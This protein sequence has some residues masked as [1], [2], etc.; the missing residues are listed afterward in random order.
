HAMQ[1]VCQFGKSL[2]FNALDEVRG[3]GC[4]VVPAHAGKNYPAISAAPYVIG[5]Q[6]LTL[7]GLAGGRAKAPE[8]G[9]SE[10]L[11]MSDVTEADVNA[12]G[13]PAAKKGLPKMALIGGGVAALLIVAGGG[14]FFLMQSGMF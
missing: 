1:E 3:R 8:I 13:S 4:L 7:C 11:R 14:G 2:Y 12:S 10:G 9:D 6:S 5:N